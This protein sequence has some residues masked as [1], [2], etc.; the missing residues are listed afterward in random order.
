M[1]TFFKWFTNITIVVGLIF[2][3]L[4]VQEKHLTGGGSTSGSYGSTPAVDKTV[5]Y[6]TLVRIDN[7]KPDPM[8]VTWETPTTAN[9][10]KWCLT[11][12]DGEKE[13]YETIDEANKK[14]EK[15]GLLWRTMTKTESFWKWI[16]DLF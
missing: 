14:L 8:K 9:G 12:D 13:E 5:K 15:Y 3:A 4:W 1:Q 7:T 2:C 11:I 6:Y 10:E 16:T